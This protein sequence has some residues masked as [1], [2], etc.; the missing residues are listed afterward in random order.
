MKSKITE[1]LPYNN[2]LQLGTASKG[3]V[4]DVLQ[5]SLGMEKFLEET[6]GVVP[7]QWWI[8]QEIEEQIVEGKAETC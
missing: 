8:T 1:G 3:V 7:S 6:S 5:Q 2:G 4:Q